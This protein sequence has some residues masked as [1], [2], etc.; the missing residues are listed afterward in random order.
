M[1]ISYVSVSIPFTICPVCLP[2]NLLNVSI[3]SG[4]KK[5]SLL[6]SVT[7][8]SPL[9]PPV[10]V[11]SNVIVGVL[12]YPEPAF[13]ILILV[14]LLFVMTTE[15]SA[16]IPPVTDGAENVIVGAVL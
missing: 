13:V 8:A 5:I 1:F 16:V 10:F 12:V 9:E 11:L 3:L 14:I 2:I 15:P 4:F 6:I 7:A